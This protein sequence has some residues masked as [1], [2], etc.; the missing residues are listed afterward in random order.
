M[1]KGLRDKRRRK[2]AEKT[3][4]EKRE[5]ELAYEEMY[6]KDKSDSGDKKK[7][8]KSKTTTNYWRV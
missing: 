6:G 5:A 3:A 7:K 8:K 1:L 2:K 4:R